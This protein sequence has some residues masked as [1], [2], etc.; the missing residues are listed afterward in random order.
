MRASQWSICIAVFVF[1]TVL[2]APHPAVAQT[3]LE[4]EQLQVDLW[5]E[6]DQPEMLVIY[7][8][9]LPAT[10]PLPASVTLRIPARVGEPNA[11]AYDDGSGALLNATYSTSQAGDWLAVTLETP[12]PIFHLEF[13]DPLERDGEQRSYTFVWPGD[14]AVGEFRVLLLPPAGATQVQTD[15]LLTPIQPEEGALRYGAALGPFAAGQETQVAVS[16]RVG[17]VIHGETVTLI[18]NSQRAQKN[19]NSTLIIGGVVVAA[20]LLAVTGVVWYTRRTK[21][22]LTEAPPQRQR[23][24]R[25]RSERRSAAPKTQPSSQG[26][27]FCT[28]CGHALNVD[29]RFCARCG[30]PTK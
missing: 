4:L 28:N 13:Y 17:T 9:R 29:D 10:A 5:P 16:Y 25:T 7:R 1:V 11:V 19:N 30:K 26:I 2:N 12:Q 21:L 20:L 23:P 18:D 3:S 27:G 15:P 24:H 8:G 22:T 14:Y 6:Y